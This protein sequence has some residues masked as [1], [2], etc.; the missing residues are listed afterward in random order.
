MTTL[1]AQF[2]HLECHDVGRF[3]CDFDRDVSESL[4]EEGEPGN[5]S[6]E[7]WFWYAELTLDPVRERRT[8]EHYGTRWLIARDNSAGF[9]SVELYET[10]EA[11]DERL[12][13]LD[14]AY[15]EWDGASDE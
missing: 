4:A 5:G 3:D 7:W 8:V 9:F 12:E 11:R 10:A 2:P 1:N 14:A 6:V 15:A 13:I